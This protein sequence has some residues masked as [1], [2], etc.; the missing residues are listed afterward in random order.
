MITG[1]LANRVL[2][3]YPLSI[4]TSL[5]LEGAMGIHPDHPSDKKELLDYSVLWVNLKTLFRNYYNA[6]D[7]E[8]VHDVRP[9]EFSEAVWQE[10]DQLT[11]VVQSET[12]GKMSVQYYVSDYANLETTY[13]KA[14]I[15]GDTTGLQRAYSAAMVGSLA[16]LIRDHRDVIKSYRLKITDSVTQP[17]LM[18]THIAFDLLAKGFTN[19]ALLESHTGAIKKKHLWYTKYHNGRE[20]SQIPFNEGFMMIFG[21]SEIFRPMAIGVRRAVLELATQYNWSQ[22]TTLAKIDYS[23]STLKDHLLKDTLRALLH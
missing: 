23:L 21:D 20:L 12:A 1:A 4:A 15:R 16:P 11:R 6:V 3:Q 13:P 2:G 9:A 18:L 5:A 7:K 19:M 8:S 14:L 17:T 10:M 22:A